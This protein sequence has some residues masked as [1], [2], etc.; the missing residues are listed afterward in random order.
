M[1]VYAADILASLQNLLVRDV[2]LRPVI[3]GERMAALKEF[4]D[5]VSRVRHAYILLN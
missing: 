4:L 3:S 5:V 1:P 2:P